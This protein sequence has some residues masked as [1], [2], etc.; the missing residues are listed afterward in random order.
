LWFIDIRKIELTTMMQD[1]R[2]LSS[3]SSPNINNPEKNV[4]INPAEEII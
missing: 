1:N 4:I 2:F 3:N